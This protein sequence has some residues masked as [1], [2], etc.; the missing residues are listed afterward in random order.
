MTSAVPRTLLVVEDDA[1]VRDLVCD[2]MRQAGYGVLAAGDGATAMALAL[3][4]RPCACLVDVGMPRVDGLE[5]T[6]RMRR[7]PAL[8]GTPIILVTARARP[9]DVRAGFEAGAS[10]HLPKPI[11]F[12][13][14]T[15]RVAELLDV[16]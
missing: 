12:A 3:Q 15:A 11:A 1:D 10:A 6:R 8:R 13:E 2:R 5:L 7:I 9:E 14:L 16:A 4:H